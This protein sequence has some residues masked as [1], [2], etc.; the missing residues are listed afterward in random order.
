MTEASDSAESGV[1]PDPA[2]DLE[3][4]PDTVARPGSTKLTRG[5]RWVTGGPGARVYE[6]LQWCRRVGWWFLDLGDALGGLVTRAPS[7][8]D[9]P[10]KVI[11]VAGRRMRAVVVPDASPSSVRLRTTAVVA[12]AL[13]AAGVEFFALPDGIGR[14]RICVRSGDAVGAL[15][16]LA[17]V[18]ASEPLH[19]G[20]VRRDRVLGVRGADRFRRR[21][22]RGARALRVVIPAVDPHT[23]MLLAMDEAGVDVELWR[24]L[25]GDVW[26]APLANR[27]GPNLRPAARVPSVLS[28][29]GLDLPSFEE[30]TVTHVDQVTFPIDVV[31]TWVNGDDPAWR[32]RMERHRTGVGSG[33]TAQSAS[34]A[35]FTDF[36]ELRYSLR[37]IA[38]Y[39]PWIRHVWLVTDDQ[40]PSWL[41]TDCPDLTVV[42]HRD[43]WSDT[44]ELPVFNSHAIEANLSR[45]EGLAEHYIYF[46]DDVLLGRDISPTQFFSPGGVIRFY[47]SSAQVG[48]GPPLPA[49]GAPS[50]A[51]KNDRALLREATQS[52]QTQKLWHTP[53]A[54]RRSIAT[55]LIERFPDA[56]AA[57]SRSRF[58]DPTDIAPVP[59][60][61]WYAYRT[62][63]AVPDFLAYGYIILGRRSTRRA[64]RRLRRHRHLDVFCLNQSDN[65]GID[66][67]R[68]RADLETFLDAYFPF[69]SRWES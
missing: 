59:L 6:F 2:I 24:V 19:V 30:L 57:T 68:V 42:S 67:A 51:A 52:I 37:S 11:R 16:A 43:I 5:L 69:K 39:A 63:R 54:Q 25:G 49:D 32:D 8:T 61:L 3:P 20:V 1:V 45:I 22:L 21:R 18:V 13:T 23:R 15:D 41:R 14:V 58:R 66:P 64:L 33:H 62:G 4:V 17:S 29:D 27:Y 60:H 55:E 38:A 44:D 36:D 53:H 12:D 10:T 9:E 35:R 28:C 26:G 31:Y 56:F 50:F 40:T 7:P 48:L 46:N 34:D 47:P 65:P